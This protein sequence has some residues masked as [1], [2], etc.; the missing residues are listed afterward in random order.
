[1][2]LDK[3]IKTYLKEY[4]EITYMPKKKQ[5]LIHDEWD[6]NSDNNIFIDI[7]HTQGAKVTLCWGKIK[8]VIGI[9]YHQKDLQKEL[10]SLFHKLVSEKK[11]KDFFK[12]LIDENLQVTLNFSEVLDFFNFE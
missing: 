6:K 7:T 3:V 9:D 4:C 5:I 2:S 12:I 1:M 11:T 8:E 10:S